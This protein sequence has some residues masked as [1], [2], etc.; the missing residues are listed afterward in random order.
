MRHQNNNNNNNIINKTLV[1]KFGVWSTS[2]SE[3]SQQ[4][5]QQQQQQNPSSKIWGMGLWPLTNQQ[6]M[7][8][9]APLSSMP[10]GPPPSLAR[11]VAL[12]KDKKLMTINCTHSYNK[13]INVQW[14]P[15]YVCT[16]NINQ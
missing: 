10:I 9:K 15:H 4:Q 5:Q 16:C 6:H 3:A 14:S 12:Q 8:S 1:S 11:A 2:P 7:S 13:V